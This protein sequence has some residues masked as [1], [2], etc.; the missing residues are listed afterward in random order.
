MELIGEGSFG[1]V[2]RVKIEGK[3]YA[4]KS[5]NKKYLIS[6]KQIKYAV[7]EATIMKDLD[8]PYV[9]RLEYAF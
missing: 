5:M 6:N 9:L 1:K 3:V 7:G 8:H 4:M 2:Y